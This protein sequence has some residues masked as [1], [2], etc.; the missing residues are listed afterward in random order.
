MST[1]VPSVNVN[2]TSVTQDL[3]EDEKAREKQRQVRTAQIQDSVSIASETGTSGSGEAL[4]PPRTQTTR[5]DQTKTAQAGLRNAY[6]ASGAKSDTKGMEGKL[7]ELADG[8]IALLGERILEME[9]EGGGEEEI[10]NLRRVRSE[11]I[12]ARD[13]YLATTQS[14]ETSGA[15]VP[16]T[17]VQSTSVGTQTGE[18]TLWRQLDS[19]FSSLGIETGG[20][21]V[22]EVQGK[23][24]RFARTE[25]KALKARET[26][27]KTEITRLT[28]RLKTASG[29][30]KTEIEN[31]LKVLKE[32]LSAVG[33]RIQALKSSVADAGATIDNII[34]LKAAKDLGIETE[35]PA[36]RTASRSQERRSATTTRTASARNAT[37]PASQGSGAGVVTTASALSG[38]SEQSALSSAAGGGG[39]GG[40]IGT[41]SAGGDTNV[42][43][44]ASFETAGASSQMVATLAANDFSGTTLAIASVGQNMRSEARR[45]DKLIKKLLRAALAGN[46]EAVKTALILL[47]KRASMITIGMGAQ[48]IKAM[49][50]YEKQMSTLSRSLGQLKGDEPDYNARLAGVNSQMNLYSMNRQAIANFLRDTL[51]MREEIA[52]LTQSVLQ[53]DQRLTSA[54]AR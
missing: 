25:G 11:L 10:Q 4:P 36:V 44:T 41:A 42:G 40:V 16:P 39:G 37:S 9:S 23:L 51:T 32:E 1:N 30:E 6:L 45:T 53:A 54:R 31:Q 26:E 50:N 20:R 22:E 21:D 34:R 13:N 28:E 48:T 52:N 7:V 15:L 47:D 5:H 17:T 49:Q 46:W 14:T 19:E 38:G 33:Q 3:R 27:I 12:Q 29:P 43:E 24:A 18:E 35:E 2:V 8:R